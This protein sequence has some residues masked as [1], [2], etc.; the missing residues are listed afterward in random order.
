MMDG[1]K[2]QIKSDEL[3][4][5]LEARVTYHVAKA[6]SYAQSSAQ[7]GEAQGDE[8]LTMSN[9]PRQSLAQSEKSHRNRAKYFQFVADHLVPNITYQLDQDDLIKIEVMDRGW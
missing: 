5:L 4:D 1:L 6:E 2:I 8:A 3:H 7:V 9:N